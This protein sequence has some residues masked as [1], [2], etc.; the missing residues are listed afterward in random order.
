[1]NGPVHPEAEPC[2]RTDALVI[3]GGAAGI[4]GAVT[5]AQARPGAR[6]V[7]LERARE[8]LGKVRL[9]GG[10]RCNVTH[11][12][13]DPAELVQ[14]YPRGGRALRGPLSRFGPRETV[15]WFAARGVTLKAEPD[16]RMFPVTDRSETVVACLLEAARKVGVEVRTQAAVTAVAQAPGGFS[17]TLKGG[18]RIFSPLLLLATGSSPQ[19]YRWAEALGHTIIP[20]VPSLFTFHVSDP[21]LAPLAGISVP[22][23]R[24][25]LEGTKLGARGPLLVTHWGVSGP[26][27]LKLSAWG[28]RELHARG[29]RMALRVS[30]TPDL[31]PE[32]LRERL[33]TFKAQAPRKSVHAHGPFGLPARLWAA[34]TLRAGIGEGKRWAELA[35]REVSSLT[36]ELGA[37]RFE[38]TGKGVF[39]EEFVTCG[40]VRLDE[41]NFK[42]MASRRRP[43]L[44]LAGEVLDIDGVTGGFNFQS[45]WATGYLAGRAM[46]E[47]LERTISS[48]RGAPYTP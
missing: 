27:V 8:A 20:P 39:K 43:G 21:H 35:K 36:D 17:V 31:H 30:W 5:L 26:A 34:L 25:R 47:A 24:V 16:G 45:A 38:I 19:G 18:E 28:A 32:A 9:S 2:E 15:A 11:H 41:V 29:Y 46:A 12:L 33:H 23:A 1:M 3:G 7:V 44:Y 13:F 40:G 6:V 14:H 4:F 10:G 42:T 37:G 22:D 48:S